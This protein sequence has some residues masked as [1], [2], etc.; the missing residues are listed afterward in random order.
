VLCSSTLNTVCPLGYIKPS[1]WFCA[2][3]AEDVFELS[4][5]HDQELTLDGLVEIQT[6]STLEEV[7]ESD[8]SLKGR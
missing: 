2:Y 3:G 8:L 1:L 4:N 7:D 5:S 6:Q